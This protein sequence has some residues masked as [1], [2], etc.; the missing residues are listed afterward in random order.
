MSEIAAAGMSVVMDPDVERGWITAVAA[1]NAK[2][3]MLGAFLEESS[4][5]GIAGGMLVLSMDELHRAVVE[6]AGNRALLL[7]EVERA[8]GRP[9]QI[10]CTAAITGPPRPLQDADVKPLI[11]RAIARFDGEIIE[12]AGRGERDTE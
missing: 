4:L 5:V 11:D 12:R 7:E 1:V 9:L 3:R 8:F 10:R 2:K 6:E